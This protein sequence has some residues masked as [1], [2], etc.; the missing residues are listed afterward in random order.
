LIHVCIPSRIDGVVQSLLAA[1]HHEDRN[2]V[3]TARCQCV[4]EQLRGD[5]VY[6]I[7]LVEGIVDNLLIH[8][9]T[10]AVGTEQILISRK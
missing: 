4:V 1:F 6:R 5:D 2:V 3:E 8:V 9:A 10:Q 7:T